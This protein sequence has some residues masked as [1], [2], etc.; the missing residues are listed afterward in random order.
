MTTRSQNQGMMGHPGAIRMI[1]QVV[2]QLLHPLPKMT[3]GGKP[4]GSRSSHGR[5]SASTAHTRGLVPVIQAEVVYFVK[6][7]GKQVHLGILLGRP[8]AGETIMSGW[9]GL[10][11]TACCYDIQQACNGPGMCLA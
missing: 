10:D 6:P 2:P 7:G 8:L 3:T 11:W 5:L 1:T 4:Y 9:S